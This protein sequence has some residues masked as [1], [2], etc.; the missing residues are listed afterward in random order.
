MFEQAFF[1]KAGDLF[2]GGF[3]GDAERGG[4]GEI[5]LAVELRRQ[6]IVELLSGNGAADGGGCAVGGGELAE[7]IGGMLD[8][9]LGHDERGAEVGIVADDDFG[10]RLAVHEAERGENHGEAE[11]DEAEATDGSY[12][13]HA[14]H[15]RI[16][17]LNL[18]KE[19]IKLFL[20]CGRE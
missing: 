8:E 2:F 17:L 18:A 12:N 11:C 9:Y 6:L 4:D 14:E 7:D 16:L 10:D 13:I 15:S 20:L 5:G 1:A 3:D 19:G